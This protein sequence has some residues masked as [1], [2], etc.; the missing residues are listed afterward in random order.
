MD[1]TL[2]LLLVAVLP[3]MQPSLVAIDGYPL[4]WADA[5]F[6]ML[7]VVI[8]ISIF[9]GRLRILWTS[10]NT[11]VAL[12][13]AATIVS[14]LAAPDRRHSLIKAAGTAYLA[15]L[16][17]LSAHYSRQ[18]E[19]RKPLLLAWLVATVVTITACAAGVVL[20]FARAPANPFLY[21]YGSL[22][23]GPYPRVMGLFT[24]A[25]MLCSYLNAAGLVVLSGERAGLIR[26]AIAVPVVVAVCLS[27]VLTLSPNLGGLALAGSLWFAATT[28]RGYGLR[29]A[30]IRWAGTA[31]AVV[32][33]V[34]ILV[35][36][37]VLNHAEARD[38]DG[39]EPSSRVQTWVAAAEVFREHPWVGA[40]P[41]AEVAHVAYV[42]ASHGYELLT[43]AHNT[44]LS[45]LAHTGLLGFVPF[46]VAIGMLIARMRQRLDV[47][48]R[49]AWRSGLELA[50]LAGLLYPS[51]SGSFEDSRHVWILMGMVHAAQTPGSAPTE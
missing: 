9:A 47:T 13:V 1:R 22:P 2:F 31:A 46:A 6:L 18:L 39:I 37:T 5:V 14:A 41:G 12:F 51:L 44:W 42:N 11:A 24:N 7:A 8:A 36:P 4:A 45:V 17:A 10:W 43:D 27:A 26:R 21:G 28:P 15:V 16:G 19:M 35:S 3:I 29:A 40:G 38:W 34:A 20:F 32:F 33:V 23:A 48:T 49:G 25:N 30:T 50:L